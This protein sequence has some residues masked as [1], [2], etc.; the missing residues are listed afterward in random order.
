MEDNSNKN[1]RILPDQEFQ[2]HCSNI[3]AWVENDYNTCILHKSIAFPLLKRLTESGDIIAKKVFKNEIVERFSSGYIPVSDYLIEENYLNYLTIEEQ[4]TL[5]ELMNIKG[6]NLSVLAWIV[7]K[8]L[9]HYFDEKF[10]TRLNGKFCAFNPDIVRQYK[11]K[12]SFFG[13]VFNMRLKNFSKS[14]LL[15]LSVKKFL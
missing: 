15:N 6:K 7:K 3:Q 4:V 14:L 12:L 11:L 5:I 1:V 2:A 10:I 8:N 9:Y 13:F